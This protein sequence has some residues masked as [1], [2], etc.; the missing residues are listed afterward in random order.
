MDDFEVDVKVLKVKRNSTSSKRNKNYDSNLKASN[1]TPITLLKVSEKWKGSRFLNALTNENLISENK[2]EKSFPHTFKER[3]LKIE[4]ISPTL[5]S[6]NDSSSSSFN[7]NA[8]SISKLSATT[9]LESD[10][11]LPGGIH[12]LII[13]ESD[14]KGTNLYKRRIARFYKATKNFSSSIVICAKS[15]SSAK[16]F[17]D[18]QIFCVVEL[19]LPLI[20]IAENIDMHLPQVISQLLSTTDPTKNRRNP[21]KF[22]IIQK[23]DLKSKNDVICNTSAD[24]AKTLCTIPGLNE[25]KAKILIEKFGSIVDISNATLK[26]LSEVLGDNAAFKVKYFFQGNL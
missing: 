21:F 18:L 22:G 6:D 16:D 19:G 20:P 4:F 11:E 12:I 7:S 13:T 15:A 24:L 10:I 17:K 1:D 14:Y 9:D 5:H 2:S 26:D 8:N 23:D 25:I 3:K